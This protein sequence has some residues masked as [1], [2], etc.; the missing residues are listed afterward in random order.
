MEE[1][2]TELTR[3]LLAYQETNDDALILGD[4]ADEIIEQFRLHW[5]QPDAQV[6]PGDVYM[7]TWLH[8]YRSLAS[9]AVSA[10]E[11]DMAIRLSGL[12]IQHAPDN[13]DPIPR[14]PDLIP[15]PLLGRAI[16]VANPAAAFGFASRLG[17]PEPPEQFTGDPLHAA[18]EILAGVAEYSPEEELRIRALALRCDVL[19]RQYVQSGQA[20]TLDEAIGAGE[21]CLRL[22]PLRDPLYRVAQAMLAPALLERAALATHDNDLDAA[23]EH[24]EDSRGGAPDD[25]AWHITRRMLGIALQDRWHRDA[26]VADLDA[27]IA[28]LRTAWQSRFDSADMVM[29]AE[30]FATS[31][32]MRA[33]LLLNAAEPLPSARA[34]GDLDEARDV[35]RDTW[36]GIPEPVQ[37]RRLIALDAQVH[38]MRFIL[39]DDDNDLDSAFI[40]A[41]RARAAAECDPTIDHF[42]ILSGLALLYQ[43]RADRRQTASDHDDSVRL[44]EQ[45]VN[46]L[47]PDDPR[48]THARLS[49]AGSLASRAKVSR[50][51]ADAVRAEQLASQALE[52]LGSDDPAR[53]RAYASLA[54]TTGALYRYSQ[55]PDPSI[56]D[57][58]IALHREALTLQREALGRGQHT[59]QVPSLHADLGTL[60]M[61]R[62]ERDSSRDDIDESIAALQAS[63]ADTPAADVRRA[64][65][66][67]KLGKALRM[68]YQSASD[69]TDLDD[70]IAAY[71]AAL[72]AAPEDA[73]Y[74]HILGAALAVRS[75]ATGNL[76]DATKA[77]EYHRAA[78]NATTDPDHRTGRL[79]S[80]G[81]ALS[82]AG[83]L[84]GDPAVLNESVAILQQAA[85]AS[86]PDDISRAEV[87]LGVGLI[88]RYEWGGA[89]DDLTAGINAY[90]RALEAEPEG[91]QSHLVNLANALAL[92]SDRT[93]SHADA[94]A[95]ARLYEEVAAATPAGHPRRSARLCALAR[96]LM[97]AAQA[98]QDPDLAAR[99]TAVTREAL[100]AASGSVDNR[101]S[102]MLLARHLLS[103]SKM[104]NSADPVREG[105]DVLEPLRDDPDGDLLDI[106]AQLLLRMYEITGDAHLLDE[107]V[108]ASERAS[109]LP[110]TAHSRARWAFDLGMHYRERFRKH[111]LPEDLEAAI[112][113]WHRVEAEVA[114]PAQWRFDAAALRANLAASQADWDSALAGFQAA[115]ALYGQLAWPGLRRED[116]ERQLSRA[117]GV[118]RDAAACAVA[119]GRPQLAL[120]LLEQGRSV[121][122]AQALEITAELDQLAAVAP[123]LAARLGEVHA[124]LRVPDPDKVLAE[125]PT[126]A[127]TQDDRRVSLAHERDQLIMKARKLPGFKDF[128]S[129]PAYKQIQRAAIGGPVVV[130]N[131]SSYRSDAIIVTAAQPP[132]VISLPGAQEPEVVRHANL[133]L[134]ALRV[135]QLPVPERNLTTTTAAQANIRNVLNWLWTAVAYPALN[136]LGAVRDTE[137]TATPI[138]VWWCPTGALSVFP[139]HAAAPRDKP[140]TSRHAV[141]DHVISSYTPTLR[142]LIDARARPR[143]NET[144]GLLLMAV[145]D[146]PGQYYLPNAVPETERIQSIYRGECTTLVRAQATRQRAL[147][148]LPQHLWVH[149]SCHGGQDFAR[150]SQGGLLLNDT[151][152]TVQDIA[153]RVSAQADLAFLS[154]CQTAISGTALLDESIHLAAAL[155]TMG[156]RHVI[157]TLWSIYDSTS[158]EIA[159]SV[160]EFLQRK[161]HP[162]ARQAAAALHEALLQ[163][164]RSRPGDPT[165]WAPYIHIG[166]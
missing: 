147:Q 60:L 63:V 93:G 20:S 47:M 163:A 145:P 129:A 16:A 154:A 48:L 98:S 56:L 46:L 161:G 124:G 118:A 12:M 24:L 148:E 18:A 40:P 155:Q 158:P 2:R 50:S 162:D 19:R 101:R 144:P 41:E 127:S 166:P 29:L 11:R 94:H 108:T 25:P 109:A 86:A 90:R 133:Y 99:A 69:L 43:A 17:S 5:S 122:W 119:S 44:Y 135:L 123:A 36:T 77:I 58:A 139:L 160:Y 126:A 150:P 21:A 84:T 30:A 52:D 138:R 81:A 140:A 151:M 75:E 91:R 87:N 31:L 103:Q 79:S 53:P 117:A 38:V 110:G 67:D 54:M 65:R 49:L 80:L 22:V 10:A 100:G 76:A 3:R 32:I 120:E 68:R 34:Q 121:L 27:S 131:I 114:A 134:E 72:E 104:S 37:P 15:R 1:T 137:P 85:E 153:E 42:N 96:T 61:S 9:P 73:G 164:R 35:L 59:R 111:G 55:A 149:F 113:T 7:L 74:L 78:V 33:A 159:V 105:L 116:Q 97:S 26:D 141:I 136:A 152:L 143:S 57:R 130:V 28:A 142:A 39:S 128:L 125:G 89:L 4:S 6:L 82:V 106:Q 88:R 95:A 157:A 45:A 115:I 14:N 132:S 70:H 107:C 71:Q 146:F 13:P 23:I 83:G 102:R 8:W 156:F 51:P 112:V 165:V 92:R 64:S 62:F 66:G